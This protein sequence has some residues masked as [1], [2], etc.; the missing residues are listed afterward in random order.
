MFKP[1]NTREYNIYIFNL[2][3]EEYQQHGE[4]ICTFVYD[5]I[6]GVKHVT[7]WSCV[8]KTKNTPT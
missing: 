2:P 5:L 7:F 4:F 1:A 6:K 8:P 3:E